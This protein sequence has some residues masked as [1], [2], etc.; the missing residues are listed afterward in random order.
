[1]FVNFIS[2]FVVIAIAMEV[3]VPVLA[4][5]KISPA[6]VMNVL[7]VKFEKSISAEKLLEFKRNVARLDFDKD[8]KLSFKEYKENKHF[9]NNPAGK[10]GFFFAADMNRDGLM[11]VN[12]Y[13]WQRII[14][15]EAK[16]I[17]F[18]VDIDRNRRVSRQEFIQNVIVSDKRLAGKIFRGLDT[19]SNG[20]LFLP[21][22][23]RVWA[24]WARASRVLRSLY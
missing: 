1:M 18:T 10:R 20:E 2:V 7:Q 9:R 22:Y 17:Y 4:G 23:L 19:N 24:R 21:E 16:K 11:S 15:D 13:A 3:Y 8:G 14:T 12:E 6:E 5:E